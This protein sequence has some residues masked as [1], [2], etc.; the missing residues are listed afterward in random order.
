MPTV[1]SLDIQISAQANK[2]SASLTTLINRL[3]RVSASLSGVNS[4]GLATMGSGVNKLSNAMNNFSNNTKTADFSRL[5]RNLAAINTVDTSGF[6]KMA[7]GISSI[8]SSLANLPNMGDK[9]DQ[10]G[11]LAK[12]IAQL[13]YKSADKAIHNIPLLASAMT[14]L[15]AQLSRAPKVSQNLIDMTNA[16]ARLSRTGASSGKAAT[17]L[18]RSF[19][20]YTASTHRATR[21]THSLASALGKMYASYWFIFRAF[22]KI[23][24]SITLASDLTEVQNVVDVT[25]GDMSYKVEEFAQTSIEQFGMSELTLKQVASQFQAMGTAVNISNKSIGSANQYLNKATNGYVG[26]ADD[27]SDVS[28]T[29]TKLTADMAS[30]YNMSQEDVAEDLQSIFTGMVQP[31][32]T[33][34]IDLTNATLKEW[35]MTQGLNSNIDAMSQ[36]EKTMLR[37]QYVLAHT[38]ASQNDFQRTSMSYANTLRILKQNF[39]QLAIIIGKTFVASLKPVVMAINN[40]MRSILNFATTVYNALGKIF[41]WKYEV[42]GGGV[43]SNLEEGE[44]SAGGIADG[45]GEAADNAEKLKKQLQGFDRLN[46]LTTDTGDD[47]GTSG[48]TGGGAGGADA[49]EWVDTGKSILEEFKSEIDSLYE[50]GQYISNTISEAMESIDWDSVY[51]KARN[52]GTGLAQFLN[53]LINPRLFGNLGKTIAGSINTAFQAL[54]AFAIEFDWKNLGISVATGI[55][56]FFENW[57]AGLSA[58]ALSNLAT[59]IFDSITSFITTLSNENTFKDIGQKIVD[60]IC[61]IKWSDLAYSLGEFFEALTTA[62]IDFPLDFGLGIAEA[63]W[64]KIS[65]QEVTLEKPKW[66][67]NIADLILA[68]IIPPLGFANIGQKIADA[69]FGT[70]EHVSSSG[71]THGGTG[72]GRNP[73]SGGGGKRSTSSTLFDK[74][75]SNNLKETANWMSLVGDETEN[76]S[77]ALDNLKTPFSEANDNALNMFKT[78][79]NGQ[80]SIQKFNED[81]NLVGQNITE[82]VTKGAEQ[83]DM[84][85]AC[86]IIYNGFTT[87]L[88][89]VFWMHSPSRRV[90]PMG[91]NIML[92]VVEGFTS[93]VNAFTEAITSWYEN[94]VQPWFTKERWLSLYENIKTSLTEKWNSLVSWW[95]SNG[96]SKWYNNNVKTW[97]TKAKWNFSGIKDGLSQAFNDAVADLKGIWEKFKE[98]I[99]DKL[100]FDFTFNTPDGSSTTSKS[101]TGTTKTTSYRANVPSTANLYSASRVS[102]AGAYGGNA[103]SSNM[104]STDFERAV[105]TAVSRVLT[106]YLAEIARNTK[107]TANKEFGITERAIGKAVQNQ[108]KIKTTRTGRDLFGRKI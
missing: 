59:G 50:L 52:F 75:S 26:L 6:S 28:L 76:T 33:Y 100:S 2:A 78:L 9:A 82:G 68:W 37:Y 23:G 4:R 106:P 64:E 99:K 62:L 13:G 16:L 12:G 63:I 85:S 97:F 65:G 29:L 56:K 88:A 10:L 94:S 57:D 24:D 71:E 72:S 14:D 84:K 1:D 105:E 17:A 86:D 61:G 104:V 18:G 102:Y 35:A 83:T 103:S 36:A 107:E 7:S 55:D 53:G 81:M 79:E 25:F 92:G 38:G 95:N 27:M 31:M 51:E 40:A 70:G 44:D 22:S 89:N 8:S 67:E 46:V 39:E 91:E 66:L 93:K 74:E 69:I 42:G 43:T 41:G 73:I 34:G 77:K 47:K 58:E 45:I 90:M 54:N 49:G 5:A 96:V 3:D 11:T 108:N 19:D 30:F 98:W 48:G 101:D 20:V 80:S 60:F 15:M 32:R 21:G 87:A